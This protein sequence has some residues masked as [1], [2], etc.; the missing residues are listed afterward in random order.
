MRDGSYRYFEARDL[1]DKSFMRYKYPPGV[2]QQNYNLNNIDK[3]TPFFIFEGAIDSFFI[4]NSMACGGASK[5]KTVLSLIDK[6]YHKNITIVFDGDKDGIQTSYA[7]LKLGYNVFVW[8]KEMWALRDIKKNKI[9]MNQ[10]VM[11]GYFDNILD[12]KGQIPC[13]QLIK[14]VLKPTLQNLLEF[15]LHYH[16][17]GFEMEDA[18]DDWS[19]QKGRWNPNPR[20]NGESRKR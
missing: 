12:E 11:T 8:N 19:F 4:A 10:L 14:H 7:F 13:E 17:F 20:Y 5:L 9:D 15:E 1:T 2:P 6:K 3:T 18:K 16:A